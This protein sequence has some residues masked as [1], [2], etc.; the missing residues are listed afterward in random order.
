MQDIQTIR[1]QKN[2]KYLQ[3]KK[4]DDLHQELNKRKENFSV[5]E[6][7]SKLY[8][9]YDLKYAP[10]EQEFLDSVHNKQDLSCFD[11]TK[12]K[13]TDFLKKYNNL[14]KSIY[15]EISNKYELTKEY[16]KVIEAI[17]FYISFS[18]EN[19]YYLKF[20]RYNAI[21]DN[22]KLLN[23][24]LSKKV[25]IIAKNNINEIQKLEKEIEKIKITNLIPEKDNNKQE[26]DLEEN[27]PLLQN[28][29]HYSYDK[30]AASPK[31]ITSIASIG[32]NIC[33]FFLEFFNKESVEDRRNVFLPDEILL[34]ILA[35]LDYKSLN[36]LA[37]TCK[38]LSELTKD[39]ILW[40]E[41]AEIQ[42][43]LL[44]TNINEKFQSKKPIKKLFRNQIF[45]PKD[46]TLI[47]KFKQTSQG[48]EPASIGIICCSFSTLAATILGALWLLPSPLDNS[49]SLDVYKF[50]FFT[51]LTLAAV[52]VIISCLKCGY[53]DVK[54]TYNKAKFIKEY[55]ET[56]DSK[57][58]FANIKQ[59]ENSNFSV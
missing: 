33:N 41:L 47:K 21:F 51:F 28:N 53:D 52:C 44:K 49:T 23:E 2:L 14:I 30:E 29:K 43:P 19:G 5:I 6:K 12:E 50:G 45:Y 57:N 32:K 46:I 37:M 40:K 20:D 11:K 18:G 39:N 10:S 9:D 58:Q 55:G 25:K 27:K 38:H 56:F 22:I 54:K 24:A 17:N 35:I 16:N 13:I 4:I 31:T 59:S 26:E 8:V 42:F 34:K 36:S 15:P 48:Y 3:E 1:Q 7:L